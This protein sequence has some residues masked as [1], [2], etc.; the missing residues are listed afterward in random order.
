MNGCVQWKIHGRP[1]QVDTILAGDSM[2]RIIRGRE[3]GKVEWVQR[4][5]HCPTGTGSQW[6]PLPTC[7]LSERFAGGRGQCYIDLRNLIALPGSRI[8]QLKCYVFRVWINPEIGIGEARIAQTETEWKE[9]LSVLGL[10]PAIANHHPFD[11]VVDSE[12]VRLFAFFRGSVHA[13]VRC[14]AG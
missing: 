8:A 7:E 2:P 9:R 13:I 1:S 11:V 6:N 3:R 4:N 10:E 14:P 5:D 12:I